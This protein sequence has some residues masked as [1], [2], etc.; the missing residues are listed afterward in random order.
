MGILYRQEREGY[1]HVIE[2]KGEKWS[3]TNYDEAEEVIDWLVKHGIPFAIDYGFEMIYINIDG[4]SWD[5][6]HSDKNRK[7][8]NK[9]DK[10]AMKVLTTLIKWKSWG[11]RPMDINHA[12]CAEIL[13]KV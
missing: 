13:K 3:Y 6:Y 7:A 12:E 9:S 2:L 10:K 8:V 5:C 11:T 1:K 4:A